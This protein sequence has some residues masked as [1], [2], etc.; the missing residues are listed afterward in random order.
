MKVITRTSEPTSIKRGTQ[1]SVQV[2]T[3][4][5]T[6]TSYGERVTDVSIQRVMRSR[7]VY[8]RLIV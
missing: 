5:I 8:F 3:K 4:A 6:K 7:I 1:T 2:G